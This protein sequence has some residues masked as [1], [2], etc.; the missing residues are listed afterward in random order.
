MEF[1]IIT[2]L[3]V[4]A[5]LNAVE[6]VDETGATVEYRVV[7]SIGWELGLRTASPCV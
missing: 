4:D 5:T 2:L 3:N 6:L 1:L 7:A